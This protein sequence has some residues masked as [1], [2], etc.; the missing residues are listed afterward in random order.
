MHNGLLEDVECLTI[1]SKDVP[2][3]L[4]GDSAYPISTWLMEPFPDSTTLSPQQKHSNYQ[5]SG[6]RAVVEIAFGCF[7]VRWRWLMKRNN[8]QCTYFSRFNS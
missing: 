7:K 2:M 4:V 1:S 5:L 6:A 3:C 8:M